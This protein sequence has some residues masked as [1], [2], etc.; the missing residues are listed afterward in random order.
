MQAAQRKIYELRGQGL[1]SNSKE[2]R[3]A[4]NRLMGLLRRS[5]PEELADFDAWASAERQ[6]RALPGNSSASH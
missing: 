4:V 2:V 3:A 1:D 6:R 5:S